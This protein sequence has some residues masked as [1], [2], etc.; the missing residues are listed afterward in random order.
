MTLS[1]AIAAPRRVADQ[2]GSLQV[3]FTRCSCKRLDPLRFDARVDASPQACVS[4]SSAAMTQRGGLRNSADPGNSAKRAPRAPMYSCFS[5]SLRPTWDRR[6][7]RSVTCTRCG[8][9]GSRDW[10]TARAISRLGAVGRRDPATRDAQV[11]Q[12]LLG[13]AESTEGVRGQARCCSCSTSHRLRKLRK[14][15]AASTEST[16]ACRRCGLRWSS[17]RSRGSWIDR[18]AAMTR[19]SSRNPRSGLDDHPCQPRVYW[20]VAPVLQPMV[21][22][23][24]RAGSR[25]GSRAPSSCSRS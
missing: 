9:A 8:C 5:A 6:P 20:G 4:T 10:A 21:V 23:R 2:C 11:V 16:S 17:G 15:D 1:Y 14:S 25:S 22:N 18:A 19:T 3:R 24:C 7:D 13:P 12:R